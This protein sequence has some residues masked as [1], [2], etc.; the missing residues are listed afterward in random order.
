M[1]EFHYRKRDAAQWDK[2]AHQSGG[3]FETFVQDD[4]RTWSAKKGSSL[5]RI[6]P[7]VHENAD[8]YGVTVW[9]HYQVGPNR[10][11]VLCLA[12]MRNMAPSSM[13][14]GKCPVCEARTRLL[15]AGDEDAASELRAVKRIMV[16]MI[17][18][19]D[20]D[21]GAMVWAMPYTVDKS[22]C[23]L[24]KDEST[25]E[26]T[27]IDHPYEGYDIA[28]ERSGE[29]KQVRYEGQKIARRSSPVDDRILEFISTRPLPKVLQ[30][31]DYQTIKDLYEGGIDPE[32]AE[33]AQ[34]R[35]RTSNGGNAAST[36]EEPTPPPVRRRTTTHDGPRTE[37]RS[38][39]EEIN[40]EVPFREDEQ[41]DEDEPKPVPVAER[42]R[43]H[44]FSRSTE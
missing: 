32:A 12:S 39:R 17:D 40:E 15:R 16:W 13:K 26:I 4:Y 19:N 18:R 11:S 14:D 2:Q 22:F 36:T 31:R 5:V 37:T 42:L 10:A 6:L 1:V 43:G 35:R 41:E 30:W 8:H 23:Q 33:P 25:G 7:P 28:F 21:R 29:G 38:Q 44:R 9:V 27:P 3:D 24:A 20:A 34:T